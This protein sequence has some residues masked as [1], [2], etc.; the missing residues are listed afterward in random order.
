MWVGSAEAISKM[1]A[2]EELT[3]STFKDFRAGNSILT[4]K[5][6]MDLAKQSI[7]CHRKQVSLDIRVDKIT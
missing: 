1:D 5:F 2:L 3:V 4:D 6:K 7:M